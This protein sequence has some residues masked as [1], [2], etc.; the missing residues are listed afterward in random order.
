MH[1][2]QLFILKF[3]NSNSLVLDF[4]KTSWTWDS[5][6]RVMNFE[7]RPHLN[8]RPL[9]KV[10]ILGM[11]K[12]GIFDD[13]QI[14]DSNSRSNSSIVLQLRSER[15]KAMKMGGPR[16]EVDGDR[17][18]LFDFLENRPVQFSEMISKFKPDF[19]IFWSGNNLNGNPC[20]RISVNNTRILRAHFGNALLYQLDCYTTTW[21]LEML[22]HQ[23]Q[24]SSLRD[25]VRVSWFQSFFSF[26][27]NWSLSYVRSVS[28][29]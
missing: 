11:A 13:W 22:P 23:L 2:I 4:I 15:Y 29:S 3:N 9:I 6:L 18:R 25:C 1:Y 20:W 14:G 8:T 24:S 26:L 12:L 19:L 17:P 10:K 21:I 16:V 5:N 28:W 27:W 7:T